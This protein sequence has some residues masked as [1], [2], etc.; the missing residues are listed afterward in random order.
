MGAAA[1]ASADPS[2]SAV[3]ILDVQERPNKT[4]KHRNTTIAKIQEPV[5]LS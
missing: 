3:L 4:R 5:R 1:G 2:G